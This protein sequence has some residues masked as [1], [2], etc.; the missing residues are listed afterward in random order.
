MQT[1]L[2]VFQAIRFNRIDVLVFLGSEVKNKIHQ[3]IY[4]YYIYIEYIKYT[5]LPTG[6]H[7]WLAEKWPLQN[8]KS[9]LENYPWIHHMKRRWGAWVSVPCHLLCQKSWGHVL[10]KGPHQLAPVFH[11]DTHLYTWNLFSLY[12][13]GDTSRSNKL[14]EKLYRFK[15]S[16]DVIHRKNP[17]FPPIGGCEKATEVGC[18]I[19][20]GIIL[21]S[22][23]GI[24]IIHYQDPY[25]PSMISK[26]GI[27]RR[28]TTNINQQLLT[29][30]LL[31]MASKSKMN[32]RSRDIPVN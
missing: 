13:Q 22:S 18:L 5:Q 32:Q 20:M 10:R 26:S 23:V 19:I 30:R 2:Y 11:W 9:A 21:P 8:F 29:K 31:V 4:I 3:Q 12:F 1:W 6:L 16:K 14:I 17:G 27:S 28:R 24:I 15:D 25:K 7:I